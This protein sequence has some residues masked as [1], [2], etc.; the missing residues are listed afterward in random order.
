MISAKG[1]ELL[2]SKHDWVLFSSSVYDVD[3]VLLE[4]PAITVIMQ[5][6]VS[7]SFPNS[8]TLSGSMRMRYQ[9]KKMILQIEASQALTTQ[10]EKKAES[11]KTSLDVLSSTDL[12]TVT[13]I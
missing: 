10:N 12:S 11:I 9:G 7:L 5:R 1:K 6:S 3:Q 2:L 8:H 4:L 13:F